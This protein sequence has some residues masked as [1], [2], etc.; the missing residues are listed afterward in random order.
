MDCND[1]RSRILP[2]YKINILHRLIQLAS[3]LEMYVNIALKCGS[4]T[5]TWVNKVA[6]FPRQTGGGLSWR[7]PIS[8]CGTW[9]FQY[10]VARAIEFQGGNKG[11]LYG[12]YQCLFMQVYESEISTIHSWNNIRQTPSN[13]ESYK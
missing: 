2:E 7:I 12:A 6:L 3:D 8:C 5:A 13:K 11:F 1:F 9:N 4:N 10:N